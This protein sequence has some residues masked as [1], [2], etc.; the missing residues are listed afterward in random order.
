MNADLQQIRANLMK[1]HE[2]DEQMEKLRQDEET[3]RCNQG[4]QAVDYDNL[5]LQLL[6]EEMEQQ[7]EISRRLLEE[8]QELQRKLQADKLRFEKTRDELAA[9]TQSQ[10]D[11]ID[12]QR[13]AMEAEQ[14]R[15]DSNSQKEEQRLQHSLALLNEK[16][17][18]L[19]EE[20]QLLQA[21]L[22]RLKASMYAQ[23]RKKP[24]KKRK[25]VT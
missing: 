23:P 17:G 21:K 5:E 19:R 6:L 10:R 13:K 1:I 11:L 7:Q 4:N 16:N 3:Q 20:K 12:R 24:A 22:E 8:N 2:L 18:K 25:A 15:Q 9:Y 14:E